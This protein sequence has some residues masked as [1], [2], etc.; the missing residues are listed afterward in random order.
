MLRNFMVEDAVKQY[1]I[2]GSPTQFRHSALY[3]LSALYLKKVTL[4]LEFHD[5]RNS[6]L[7]GNEQNSIAPYQTMKIMCSVEL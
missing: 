4:I 6:S 2:T 1:L 7:C 3:L 5:C